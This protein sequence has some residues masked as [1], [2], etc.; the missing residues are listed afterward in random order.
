MS[1]NPIKILITDDIEDNRIV[2]KT[3][4][5]KLNNIEIFEAENGLE[6][7]RIVE[8][9]EIDIVLMDVMMPVMDGFEAAKIIKALERPPYVLIVT[10]VTDKETEDKFASIGVDGY[11]RKPIDKEAILSRV[12]ALKSA[13]LIKKGLKKWPII[14]KTAFKTSREMQKFQ[15]VFFD[16]KRRR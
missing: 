5:K 4:C 8:T 12:E 10:A 3:I 15:N 6:A 11:I 1:D 13:C 14:Q 9:K 16:R 2:L 7:T